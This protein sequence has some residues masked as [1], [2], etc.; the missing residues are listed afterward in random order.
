MENG[1]KRSW[2][3]TTEPFQRG[4]LKAF[5]SE[6]GRKTKRR[7]M[8]FKLSFL[9]ALWLKLLLAFTKLPEE[10]IFLLKN[11]KKIMNMHTI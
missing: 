2:N 4:I 5:E 1:W 9:F 6:V 7:M 3:E 11:S 8:E 10:V